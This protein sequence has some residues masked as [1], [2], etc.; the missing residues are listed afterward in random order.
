MYTLQ[1][2][3][4]TFCRLSLLLLSC[5]L[6]GSKIDI[7]EKKY[8]KEQAIYRAYDHLVMAG[9]QGWFAAEGD[10]S[11]RGWYHLKGGLCGG[12]YPGCATIDFFPDM[13]EYKKTYPTKF[14]YPDG[15]NVRMFSSYDKE[16]TGLHF[17]WMQEY[18]IDG[19]HM[20][21]FVGEIKKTNPA[22][23]RHFNKVLANALEA[24]KKYGRAI[25]IMYDLSGCSSDDIPFILEDLEE[26]QDKFKLSDIRTNPTFLHH[27]DKPLIS[28]WGVG[29][30][31]GR[32]YTIQ[33]VMNLVDE[34]RQ[35][36]EF[37]I[38][39]GIPYYWR[40]LGRDTEP[41]PILH[42]LIKKVDI[43]MPWAVGRYNSQSYQQTTSLLKGD[44]EWCKAN[45]V[46][47]VPLVFPGF[48]WGNMHQDSTIYNAIPRDKGD[49]LWKQV[50]G[51]KRAGAQSLYVAMFDEIDEGT[52]IFKCARQ[53]AVP[54][55]G[56]FKFVGIEDD[57]PS[58]HYLWL[59]GEA[60]KWFHG[61]SGYSATKPKR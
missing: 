5:F 18:G 11:K 29:F 60:T 50:A 34:L 52:A 24:A 55:N 20:Q 28:I 44:I 1:M 37:S 4:V 26:L 45:D 49:F 31:D 12:F 53:G 10:E 41:N 59:T 40:N 13:R 27:N 19:V 9:Y 16:T 25:S 8:E 58:D 2:K 3:K 36:G 46:A 30:N 61:N 23:R 22:G 6:M 43:I 42:E 33:D 57:L 39:L 14:S 21:R 38:L 47:Y 17:K 54:L 7:H 48:S 35:K 51:A 56:Q 15:S 32:K